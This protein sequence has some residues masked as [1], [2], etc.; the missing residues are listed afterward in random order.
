VVYVPGIYPV[1]TDFYIPTED[2]MGPVVSSRN[3]SDET[4][5]VTDRV[6]S[7]AAEGSVI[8]AD[9]GSRPGSPTPKVCWR[10]PRYSKRVQSKSEPSTSSSAV[11]D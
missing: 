2:E 7:A 8:E 1:Y 5:S 4:D 9:T 11:E 6:S 3:A 10:K